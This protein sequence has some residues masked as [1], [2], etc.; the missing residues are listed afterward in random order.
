MIYTKDA[1]KEKL[2]AYTLRAD[3]GEYDSLPYQGELEM[4][5]EQFMEYE[6]EIMD[7]ITLPEERHLIIIDADRA[8]AVSATAEGAAGLHGLLDDLIA[9]CGHAEYLEEE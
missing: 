4:I 3:A 2:K 9:V 6:S 8:A 7:H 5:V 1:G